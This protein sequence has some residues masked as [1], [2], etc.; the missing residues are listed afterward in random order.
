[1]VERYLF[2]PF[3][4]V[5]TLLLFAL[6]IRRVL[7]VRLGVLR[8]VLATLAAVLLGQPIMQAMLADLEQADG[9]SQVVYLLL[10]IA[11][12]SLLAMILVVLA[13]VLVPDGS[14]P[15]PLELWRGSRSRLRRARRYGQVIRI[16]LRH[17]LG[18]FLRG[19]DHR[20]LSSSVAR[21]ELARSLRAAL[22]EGGITFVKLGQQLSTRRDLLPAEFTDELTGLQ[23]R[24]APVPWPDVQALLAAELP[25]L[26]ALAEIDPEPLAAASVAQ[27]HSGRLRDGR[28]VIVKVQRPGL[29]AVVDRDLDILARLAVTLESRTRWGRSIGARALAAGFAAALRE[30]LD[31]TVERDNMRSVGAL[32]EP[33][34]GNVVS[35]RVPRP[36]ADLCTPRVLVMER[37]TGTPLGAADAV[38]AGWDAAERRA[39]ADVLLGMVLDQVL[40]H[41]LF[42]VDLHPG[43]VL[44]GDDRVLGLLDFGSV[45]RLDSTTRAGIGRLLVAIGRGDSTTAADALLDLVDRPEEIDERALERAVGSLIVR[46]TT[47]GSTAGAAAFSA[48]FRLVATYRLGVPPQVAAVFRAFATLEGTLAALDP[49]IDLLARTRAIGQTRMQ[50]AAAPG[51][52]RRS[53]EDELVSLLPLLRRL[54][55]RVDRIADSLEHGR[56]GLRVRLLADPDDRRMITGMLHQTLLTVIGGSSGLMAVLL[57]RTPGGP[58]LT[59]SF[60]LFAVLGYALLIVA[61]VLALRI[62]LV[63]F[64]QDPPT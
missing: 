1:M 34:P 48:L 17:G 59:E 7:G 15:S 9:G 62:L 18:R 38:L 43:N 30:E 51:E 61:V 12:T 16:A 41:G 42:H 31:F 20:G 11:T 35:V 6:A 56:F 27:V 54:P 3:F 36:L 10:S 8:T 32:L 44:V 58:R 39:A 52:L 25:D 53:L 40:V 45:G 21:R 33:A 26:G 50:Q 5:L 24:A 64:R 23:D 19:R 49:G 29:A 55:R 47:P 22:D 37:L 63:V 14:L 57:L 13:E 46:W 2:V 4:F 60:A 28:E